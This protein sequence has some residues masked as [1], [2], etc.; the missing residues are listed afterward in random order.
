MK[1][2]SL[3]L[4]LCVVIGSTSLLATTPRTNGCKIKCQKP[5]TKDTVVAKKSVLELAR[6]AVQLSSSQ[7]D[8]FPEFMIGNTFYKI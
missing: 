4:F 6:K 1:Q 7:K 8:V 3:I 2:A 5:P